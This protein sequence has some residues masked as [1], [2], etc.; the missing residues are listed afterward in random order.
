MDTSNFYSLCD[1]VSS[2]CAAAFQ[3]VSFILMY[4]VGRGQ[5][6][7]I[8]DHLWL[9]QVS[10]RPLLVPVLSVPLFLCGVPILHGRVNIPTSS[11]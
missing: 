8:L 1:L 9:P 5:G 10:V 4:L 11:P 7:G 2:N 6:C 3:L